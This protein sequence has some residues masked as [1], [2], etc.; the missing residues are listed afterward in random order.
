MNVIVRLYA[1]LTVVSGWV[2]RLRIAL[3]VRVYGIT[4]E[5]KPPV[6]WRVREGLPSY[7]QW[8]TT[9]LSRVGSNVEERIPRFVL[10]KGKVGVG[11]VRPV[12]AKLDKEPM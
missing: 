2:E 11:P 4:N 3:L 5:C 10:L 9:R 8:P 1:L 12:P 6:D 7:G